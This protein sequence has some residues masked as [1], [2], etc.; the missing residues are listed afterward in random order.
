MT[1]Y[2][3]QNMKGCVIIS[4]NEEYYNNKLNQIKKL[5]RSKYF[6]YMYMSNKYK[7]YNKL[8]LTFTYQETDEY[9]KMEVIN[10]I[11]NYFSL[12][13]RN[14]RNNDI[15]FYSN[16]ELGSD[17]KN[18]HIHIQVWY[19]DTINQIYTIRDKV[20]AEFG[21]FSE[22]SIISTP[23]KE[24]VNY[25]YVVKD[26]DNKQD[27]DTLLKLDYYKRIYRS[28][29]DKKIRFTSMS[30]EKYSKIVYKRAYSR[31]VKKLHVDELIDNKIINE[32][33]EIVDNALIYGFMVMLMRE[34]IQYRINNIIDR[35]STE[36]K[37]Q[38]LHQKL[39]DF[40]ITGFV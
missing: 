4:N 14:T 40:W 12:L 19:K 15:K 11:K 33:I 13:I 17:F 36:N 6:D 18:P 28:V 23:D 3:G 8:M 37:S 2:L 25:S 35:F 32:S 24:N 39:I 34:L 20:I 31:G 21:L 27:D 30:K 5:N 9:K 29:L 16:I 38:F 26:Y 22:Y 10:N 7:N 1:L